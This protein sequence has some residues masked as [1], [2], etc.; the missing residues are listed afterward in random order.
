MQ[1]G[2]GG[3]P[4]K[5]KA[6]K[7][8]SLN[9]PGFS[10]LKSTARAM[11]V[12]DRAWRTT[13]ARGCRRPGTRQRGAAPGKRTGNGGRLWIHIRDE[14]T[15]AARQ[16]GFA[17]KI[18]TDPTHKEKRD[19]IATLTQPCAPNYANHHDFFKITGPRSNTIPRESLRTTKKPGFRRRWARGDNLRISTTC[20]R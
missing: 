14:E 13:V 16:S 19:R 10:A 9:G 2:A 5:K 1:V 8:G 18:S 4:R 20:T 11:R 17:V 12:S 6:M 3:R 7:G 15:T